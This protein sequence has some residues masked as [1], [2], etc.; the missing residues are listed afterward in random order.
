MPRVA[1]FRT[2][3]IRDLFEQLRYAPATARERE[4]DAI[5]ALVAD[6]DPARNYPE[7][8]IVYRV[9]GYRPDVAA[10]ETTLVGAALLG[11]LSNLVQRLSRDLE[12]PADYRGRIALSLAE[13][14]RR[15]Q[16]SRKTIQRY[17]RQGLIC[18]Y[19][20]RED[21]RRG[22]VC[23]ADALE[24]FERLHRDQLERA[25]H[26]T[27]I[28]TG[29]E[30]AMLEE[31]RRLHEEHGLSLHGAARHLARRHGRA[32][33]TMR[34]LLRRA[35]EQAVQPIFGEHGPL[36]AR[37][38]RLAWRARRLGV[39][40][41][42]IARRF[43][44]TTPSIHRAM[45]RHRGELLRGL[46]LFFVELPT[47]ELEDA[48]EVILS[49]RAVRS[50]LLDLLPHDDAVILLDAVWAAEDVAEADADAMLAAFNF[51]KR[52]A[53][54]RLAGLGPWPPAGDLDEIETALRWTSLLHRRLVCVG[55][56]AALRA[57]EQHHH[58]R[59]IQQPGEALVSTI[60]LAVAVVSRTIG[61]IDPSRGQR[62]A[63]RSAQ[64]MDRALATLGVSPAEHRAA[65]RHG[66]GSLPVPNLFEDLCPWEGWLSLR[67]DWQSHVDRLPTDRRHL[68]RRR[69]GLDGEPPRTCAALAEELGET[70]S[71]IARRLRSTEQRLRRLAA[72]RAENNT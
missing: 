5:E 3:A 29:T 30:E 69:F 31:A 14:G 26:F 25:A 18:H 15:L 62:I 56:P 13:V 11:E 27:R 41:V 44:K 34:M 19:V 33:E 28:D 50:G 23:F 4:M 51:L 64:A 24:R 16:V 60:R 49:A 7:D 22:L 71:V 48:S 2:D 52:Q 40:L 10:S 58:R 59:L 72:E 1:A 21:G 61:S 12:L 20:R 37:D 17:R 9:T 45:N 67:R 43:G 55:L 46:N 38:G 32:V 54:E 47:F 6:I 42:A 8:F 35:D 63:R 39:P 70:V 68:V 65:A 36:S 57:A 53:A 66:P